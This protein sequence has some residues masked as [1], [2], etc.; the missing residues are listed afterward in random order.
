MEVSERVARQIDNIRCAQHST[1]TSA[2]SSLSIA[3]VAESHGSNHGSESFLD[4]EHSQSVIPKTCMTEGQDPG[5]PRPPDSQDWNSSRPKKKRSGRALCQRFHRRPNKRILYEWGCA[6]RVGPGCWPPCLLAEF[7][8][9][10]GAC[11][12]CV[13]PPPPSPQRKH[14]SVIDV[15]AMACEEAPRNPKP[16]MS[17][18]LCAVCLRW[19]HATLQCGYCG[20]CIQDGC[21]QCAEEMDRLLRTPPH[22]LLAVG[23]VRHCSFFAAALTPWQ[24]CDSPL[25]AL[26]HG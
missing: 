13:P 12:D 3:L 1:T 25:K 23:A 7:R 6:R 21:C 20:L 26:C 17:R 15:V 2:S 5:P 14:F 16:V 8:H 10:F 22:H 24:P 4:P 9:G 11:V 19:L 18:F